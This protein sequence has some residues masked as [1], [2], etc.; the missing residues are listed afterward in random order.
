MTAAASADLVNRWRTEKCHN[1]IAPAGIEHARFPLSFHAG[2]GC[3][4][5][6]DG[7]A[8]TSAVTE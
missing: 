5:F 6:L 3:C 4:R 8:Y 2:R 1:H 7:L